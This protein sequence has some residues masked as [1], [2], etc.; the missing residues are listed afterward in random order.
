MT[1]GGNGRI[2]IRLKPAASKQAIAITEDGELR[3]WVSA[4][5]VDGK[6]NASLIKLLAKA[7]GLPKTSLTIVRGRTA[8]TKVIEVTGLST[9][10][11]AATL[12][13]HAAP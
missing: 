10:R 11:I 8:R 6:A 1:T 4:P 13:R 12:R 3:V 5:P 9:D 2:T 7:L